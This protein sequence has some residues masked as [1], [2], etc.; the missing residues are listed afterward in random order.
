MF[1]HRQFHFVINYIVQ[2]RTEQNI[3]LFTLRPFCNGVRGIYIILSEQ[4]GFQEDIYI[5]YFIDT[6]RDILYVI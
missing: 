2:N 5:K 4:D 6:C 1:V 3:T